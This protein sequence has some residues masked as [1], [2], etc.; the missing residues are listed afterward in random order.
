MLVALVCTVTVLGPPAVAAEPVEPPAPACPADRPKPGAD[1]PPLANAPIGQ[2]SFFSYPNRSTAER[3]AIRNRVL[4]TI[5]STWGTWYQPTWTADPVPC[6]GE[7]D[8]G[9]YRTWV[10]RRGTIRMTT[11]SFNDW[12]VRDALVR[13]RNRGA[14][15]QIIAS[16]GIN[17]REGYKPWKSLKTALNTSASRARGNWA[18]ECISACRGRGGTAHAKYFLFE[19]V[20]TRHQVRN[21]VVQTSMNLTAFAYK[22]QWNQA[23]VLRNR[24]DV[25]GRYRGV[26]NQ[27]ATRGAT[28]MGYRRYND[29][30]VA[31]I[32]FP[33]GSTADPVLTALNQVRCPTRIRV[34]QYAIY[35]TR[36]NA[37]AKRLR[38]MWDRGCD[39]RIIYS[40]SS[41]PVL[42]VLR[43][44]TG[45]GPIPMRQ[46]VIKNR[47]G[48]VVKYNHSKWLALAGNV[49]GRSGVWR[50][51]AG[52]ANWSDLAFTSDEQ[53]QEITGYGFTR[54]YFATFDKTWGQNTSKVPA[55][56]RLAGG[57]LARVST[58]PS[59]GTGELRHLSE[60][61]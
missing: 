22:G 19:D 13:A 10:A 20:G 40:V 15:V 50:V 56:G 51:H 38:T 9:R 27:A 25:F 48:E 59:W 60:W 1:R 21:V 23:T 2:G 3:M 8:D 45:R 11:W 44:R 47:R 24:D 12:G 36:G 61:G 52:S 43:S 29:G 35:G 55:Y 17:E 26:F 6:V 28:G 7:N 31:S 42:K 34:I 18:R 39:V 33:K 46:S 30:T 16:R 32:F 53:M 4:A 54:P 58:Q 41:R 5:N 37:V 57:T 49:G 14:Q